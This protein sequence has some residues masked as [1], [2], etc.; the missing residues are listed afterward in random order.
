MGFVETGVVLLLAAGTVDACC[1]G[2]KGASVSN[3]DTV[4]VEAATASTT[5]TTGSLIVSGGLGVSKSLVA[6][7]MMVGTV[8]GGDATGAYIAHQSKFTST[9]FAMSQ[10]SSGETRLNSKSGKTMSFRVNNIQVAI[11]NDGKFGVNTGN[12]P[13]AVLEANGGVQGTSAYSQSSDRRFKKDITALDSSLARLKNL[14]GVRRSSARHALREGT[15]AEPPLIHT[16]DMPFSN[17]RRSRSTGATTNSRAGT[18]STACK[19]A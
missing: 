16:D 7:K 3:F 17:S 12:A 9:N 10:T 5:T 19:L 1:V 8:S 2:V 13:T 14:S 4:V 6:G 11:L 15:S 18:S